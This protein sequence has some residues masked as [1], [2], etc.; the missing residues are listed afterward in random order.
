ML[1]IFGGTVLKDNSTTNDVFWMT[2]DRMEWHNQPCK[3]EKPTPRCEG[4]GE[5]GLRV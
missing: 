3:G 4:V 5:E 2:L 1:L